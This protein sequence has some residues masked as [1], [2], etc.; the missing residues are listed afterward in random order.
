MSVSCGAKKRRNTG[1]ISSIF[2]VAVGRPLA[3]KPVSY[4]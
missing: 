1:G 2:G 3:A 4:F